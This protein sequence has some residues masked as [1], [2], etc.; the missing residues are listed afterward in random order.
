MPSIAG[1]ELS[2]DSILLQSFSPGEEPTKHPGLRPT[3]Q[4]TGN[5]CVNV[6][7]QEK[8]ATLAKFFFCHIF[9]NQAAKVLANS[10]TKFFGAILN[11]S[12]FTLIN[13]KANIFIFTHRKSNNRTINPKLIANAQNQTLTAIG[14]IA[15]F[16][17]SRYP[18]YPGAAIENRDPPP[19]SIYEARRAEPEPSIQS[20]KVDRFDH[21]STQIANLPLFVE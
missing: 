10:Y 13:M 5:V 2:S 12:F 20:Q 4:L 1:S 21:N 6:F 11:V 9:L 17:A 18:L 7:V 14:P 3:R 15:E 19:A 16:C 8:H